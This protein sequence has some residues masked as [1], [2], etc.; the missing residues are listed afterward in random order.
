MVESESRVPSGLYIDVENLQSD[1]KEHIIALLDNWP[2]SAPHPTKISLYVRADMVELWTIWTYANISQQAVEVNGVQ[3]FTGQQSKN[4]ADIAIAVE[5]MSDLLKDRVRHV[6]V[7]SD[8]SDFVSL[9]SKIRTETKEIQSEI[10][11]IPFLWILTNRHGTKSPNIKEFFPDQYLHIVNSKRHLGTSTSR[12]GQSTRA[13]SPEESIAIAIIRETEV[14][15]FKSTD[16]QGLVNDQ[17]S[18]YSM[19]NQT[20][21]AFGSLFKNEIWPLL[22]QRGVRLIRQNSPRTYE[23]TQEAKDSLDSIPAT[24]QVM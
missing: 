5:A 7:F 9:F 3:H 20:N 6:A 12:S 24:N 11:R 18:D 1:A 21:V 4:S 8:D 15:P 22:Q 10:G 19:A 13:T 14:G 23:M 2:S 16:C 17:F